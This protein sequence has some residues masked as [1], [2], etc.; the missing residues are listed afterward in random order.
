MLEDRER[1]KFNKYFAALVE[2]FDRAA[3]LTQNSTFH[4]FKIANSEIEIEFAGDALL[5]KVCPALEH[6]RVQGRTQSDFKIKCWDGISSGVMMPPKPWPESERFVH[7]EIRSFIDVDH[8][9]HL[10]LMNGAIILA[11]RQKRTAIF[12]VHSAEEISTYEMAAPFRDFFNW[13]GSADEIYQIHAGAVAIGSAGALII[14]RS[15]AGKSN[16]MLACLNTA[17]SYLSDDCCLLDTKEPPFVHGLYNST[18]AY[19]SDLQRY[20][21]L[22]DRLEEGLKTPEDKRLF[23]LNRIANQRLAAGFEL[24]VILAVRVSHREETTLT[25]MSFGDALLT[26]A[27]DNILRWPIVSRA[28]LSRLARTIQQVPCHYLNVGLNREQIP[29][30]IVE[31]I[32]AS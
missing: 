18:K 28:A 2:C 12:C 10:N 5:S 24:K 27:P 7:G 11:D 13:W 21:I 30:K 3:E 17:L 9:L 4:Y 1:R 29:M 22:A 20:P 26:M 16:T 23:F 19:S 25:P 14:G 32:R 8:Y 15:G 31:A 6:L